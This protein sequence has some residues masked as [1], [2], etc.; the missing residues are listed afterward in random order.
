MIEYLS[1]AP[2]R[3]V[4][5]GV[6]TSLINPVTGEPLAALA[7]DGERLIPSEGL[8]IDEIGPV[9]EIDQETGEIVASIPRW[10]VNLA[11]TGRLE[12]LLADSGGWLAILPMLGAMAWTPAVDGA[13]SGFAGASGMVIYPAGTVTSRVR[14]W[15][16]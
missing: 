13:A 10:H 14:A 15:M 16:T 12:A 5:V 2:S 6:M 1:H 9:H 8:L 11:A 4:F 3:A 7:E